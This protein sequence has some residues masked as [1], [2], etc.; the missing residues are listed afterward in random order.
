MSGIIAFFRASPPKAGAAFDEHRFRRVRWQTFIAMT[1]AYVTFYVCRLSF[2]VAKSALVELGITPTELGM[3]G[4]TLF[5]SYAIG[6][7]VNGF[8]ADH[9]NVV[10]YMSLGLLLS[11]GMN[12]MMGMTTNALLLAIFWGINGWAQ[13]MGVGPCAVSLARWYGVK[14]RGTFY[15]IWSTAHNIGEAVT[16]MV[17]AAV[18]AGFGWQMGYLSTAALGAA[19]V[20]LLVL[21]M[22]DSPQS[23]G[24]P[25]INVIRDE[26]QEEV[27]ARGSVFK[28]QLLALRNPALWTLALASAFMYIDRYAVN[29]W[30]IFFLEQDKAYSTLE[31]SGIIG[32]NAIAG[33]AGTIIAGMLSDRFFP[34]N[35]SVMAGF[36]SLLNT[37]GFALMLWSPH[38]YYTDILAMI[39]FG[40]TIGALTCFL[41]GLIASISLRA[42]PPGPRSA[43]SASP[44]TP[45]PAWASF[46]PGSLLIKRLSLKTA[47][48]CMISAR[49]RC[50][51]WVPVW[52]PRYSVLP[53]P[54]SSPGAMPSN[55][56]PR[57]PHNRLTN[58]EED[59]MPARHQG[60]LRLFIACALP[61]LALQSAAAADWQLEKVVELSRHGIRPPTAGNREAIE[62]ATGRPWTEWTTHD[63]ELTGHGYAAVVNKGRA[64]GQHY[65][66]LGLLQAGCPTAES[67]YVRASPLQ[68]TRATA[69]ALVDGAFPGCGVAIHYVSGDAD[70]LF[71]TDKFA[72]TQTDP[73]RQLEAVKEKAGDLAQRRQ[74]LAPTIQ[75]LKQAVCQ[76]DKPCP[77][78]DTPWQVEQSKSG[79]TTIS[80]L[81]V[82]ANMVETLRLG[83]SEN[84]PLSQLAWGKITQARQITALLPLLT[85]NYDLS[86][87]VL[88]TAQKRG[89]VLLN[90]MLDGVKPEAN[91]NVRWL[92]L[93]AHDT[94]IAMVRTLMNFSWQLP[95]YSRG[96]I[97][98]GSSLVLERW[99]NA[100][101][102]ERYLRVYFQAQG[103]DDL[104]RLQTPDAQHPMLRQE[105]HQ[106]G[107]R[108]T[109][110][111][112]LCPFQAAITALGQRI[113]RSSAPAV[114]MVLP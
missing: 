85:E 27:E 95:G 26:P 15:G 84:L 96:N 68:R 43:P 111:G 81:S 36:I 51:G 92:L 45:A 80:G 3:I 8:I 12:L 56:R 29:S 103:L 93:V 46:S 35:R 60:L 83:W 114:A 82:M 91:P 67:I 18:I 33:I 65:R 97:P 62:A 98:P 5:F 74:A 16:Y 113:D 34:R 79:K 37:A 73:A 24:F 14:E 105:W 78:F 102:G 31:A 28:N 2:T 72:A 32:V 107:C 54:P 104:R 9:A 23:S 40:A 47:K 86:N 100:K 108:Q 10:R 112:T 58:K 6:K 48:R 63:G 19:G 13:S 70:P 7:L 61:L 30:G 64:E 109:D 42:R 17:I 41:G 21:F 69:Q 76:A 88:Y 71:Q 89:S 39:I 44:A 1:L 90:A 99:R 11:A 38:N 53:L 55:G 110:V 77:I 87:D 57:S 52:V 101:S 49:W 50:S 66:Q 22:H 4:S 59:M 25:S 94:N 75:L 106:P 20:V